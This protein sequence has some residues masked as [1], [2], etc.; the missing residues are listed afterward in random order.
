[1]PAGSMRRQPVAANWAASEL[2]SVL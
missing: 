1:V 2:C